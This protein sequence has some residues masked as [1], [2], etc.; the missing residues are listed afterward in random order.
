MS[1]WGPSRLSPALPAEVL[2]GHWPELLWALLRAVLG[3]GRGLVQG[4]SSTSKTQT[5]LTDSL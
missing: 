3:L 5:R 4:P 2:G 1:D